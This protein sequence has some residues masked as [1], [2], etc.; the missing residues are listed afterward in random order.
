[1]AKKTTSSERSYGLSAED[2]AELKAEYKKTRKVPNPHR[3]NYGAIVAALLAL[4]TDKFHPYEKFADKVKALMAEN[5]KA[6][7]KREARNDETG[8]DCAERLYQNV[9]VLQRSADYGA[10]LADLG[11]VIGTKGVCIDLQRDEKSNL[12]IRLSTNSAM[13]MKPGRANAK[14]KPQ[15]KANGKPTAKAPDKRPPILSGRD[16]LK[17]LAHGKANKGKGAQRKAA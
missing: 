13:P 3:G 5:W 2:V 10:R 14:P 12:T 6:F 9:T 7:A 15:A 11:K 8:K 4:G 1:M 17:A 16:A